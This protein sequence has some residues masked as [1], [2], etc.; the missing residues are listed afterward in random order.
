MDYFGFERELDHLGFF[1][2]DEHSHLDRELQRIIPEG[3][4]LGLC[5][6]VGSGKTRALGRASK[7]LKKGTDVIVS[8]ALAVDKE[9]VNVKTLM[10]A[11]FYDLSP[12]K[13]GKMPS[14]LEKLERKV[15]GFISQG[16]KP[17]VLFIDDAHGL[18]HQTLVR[19]EELIE[20]VGQ[21]GGLLSVVL[22]GHPQLEVDLRRPS[23]EASGASARILTWEGIRVRQ[24]EFI[25][26]VLQEAT[27][28][29]TQPS[30]LLAEDALA[31]LAERL[32]TPLQV[33]KYLSLIFEAAYRVRQKP[34]SA[35]T[36]KNILALGLGG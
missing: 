35:D 15:L 17:V 6:V 19:L 27:P 28:Q 3:R 21:D 23:L 20:L 1:E 8:R 4:L 31:L 34:V 36:V 24:R 7:Q 5:G 12:E 22:A 18:P 11:L 14:Q 33:E 26:W 13:G 2:T 25:E 9:R 30:D 16:R 32:S 29:G 10:A